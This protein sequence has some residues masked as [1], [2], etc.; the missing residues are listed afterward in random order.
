MRDGSKLIKLMELM[1]LP[2][3]P[4]NSTVSSGFS[5]FCFLMNLF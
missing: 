3:K 2:C 1:E 4:I 5:E